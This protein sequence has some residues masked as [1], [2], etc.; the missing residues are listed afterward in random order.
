LADV[1]SVVLNNH[2][3][4][5]RAAPVTTLPGYGTPKTAQSAG[6]WE[7]DETSKM[8]HWLIEAKKPATPP[9]STP[10][11]VWLQGGPGVSS[12]TGAMV[13][14]GPYKVDTSD[15]SK[16][17][18]NPFSWHSEAH[19]MY[20]DQPVGTGFSFTNRYRSSMEE[21]GQD[22]L[23]GILQFYEEHPE[24]RLNPLFI[25]GES[26]AGK[27]LP[28]WA[29]EIIKHNEKAENRGSQ[30]PLAGV[31]IGDG[32]TEPLRITQTYAERAYQIGLVDEV[33]HSH[34]DTLTANCTTLVTSAKSKE[35]WERAGSVCDNVE[36]ALCEMAGNVNQYDIREY[37]DYN[38]SLPYLATKMLMKSLH[39]AHAFQ[40]T[41]GQVQEALAND[42]MKSVTHLLPTILNHT[43]VLA[44]NGLYDMDCNLVSTEQTYLSV[45]WKGQQAFASSSRKPLLVDGKVAFYV[46]SADSLTQ[47]VG[48]GGG[49][50]FPMDQPKNAL[51]MIMRWMRGPLE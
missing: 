43:R 41:A 23:K 33:Q 1:A 3:A 9:Q 16:L 11:L 18:D 12:L 46:R 30:I 5:R 22:L 6:Y 35:E 45:P 42:E 39:A 19:L 49:H 7:I 28:Q 34:L 15:N 10:L 4:A 20:I 24:M 25:S 27:Y 50:L 8:F 31:A 29:F 48:I 40:S 47:A 13:E 37:G 51:A 14:N 26:Y 21:V 17:V 32:W 2:T 36:T 44:Y 38:F